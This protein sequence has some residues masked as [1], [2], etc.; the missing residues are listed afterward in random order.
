VA[1]DTGNWQ[2]RSRTNARLPI[3]I[4][5]LAEFSCVVAVVASPVVEP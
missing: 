1:G 5:Y 2:K 3:L 4:T